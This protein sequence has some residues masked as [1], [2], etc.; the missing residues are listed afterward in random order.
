M[1]LG[2][3]FDRPGLAALLLLAPLLLLAESRLL[4]RRARRLLDR[5]GPRKSSLARD[6]LPSRG[7]TRAVLFAGGLLLACAA[8]MRPVWGEEGG[9]VLRRGVDVVLCLDVSRSMLAQD[10]VPSRLE[11]AKA[12]LAGL[13]RHVDGDRLALVAFAGDARLLV[14][15]TEDG[16]SFAALLDEADPL[17]VGRGGTDLG[18]ALETALDALQSATGDARAIVLLTDGEDLAGHGREVAAACRA[19]GVTVHCVGF[20][21]ERGSK[22]ALDDAG[23]GDAFL[24][25]RAGRDVVSSRD[26]S[27]LRA[28]A[29][30]G[31]GEFVDGDTVSAPLVQLFEARVLP[32]A[33]QAL[34]S[35]GRKQRAQ[36]FQWPLLGALLLWLA[37]LAL[38]E[39]HRVVGAR[40]ATS[41]RARDAHAVGAGSGDRRGTSTAALVALLCA[42]ATTSCGRVTDDGRAAFDDGRFEDARDAFVAAAQG[43]G[44]DAPAVLHYDAALAALRAG[45]PRSA[46]EALERASAA[47]DAGALFASLEFLRGNVAMARAEQAAA[48]AS[49]PEAEPFAWDVAVRRAEAARDAWMSA[50]VTRDDWPEARRNVE[51]AA[52]RLLEFRRAREQAAGNRTLDETKQ[53]R[54]LAVPPEARPTATE[55]REEE[56]DVQ[57]QTDELSAQDVAGLMQTLAEKERQKRAL[58]SERR[59]ALSS[60]VE[61][62]W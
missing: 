7:R 36:R 57:A 39:R 61:R 6:L 16:A 3:L 25:D 62:D 10:S 53:T 59:E 23:P 33:E 31:G 58:R 30:A 29:S 41:A 38:P 51:R 56:G 5:L 50:A 13:A 35:E 32:R 44:A 42:L 34:V 27:G 60:G 55:T 19:H 52:R 45:D 37:E 9:E 28:L 48:Q 24:R 17:A 21:S 26:A 43:D 46:G 22:I 47:S 40:A 8:L 14:P 12:E 54:I 4:A 1:N 15:L 2:E 11:R 18:A 49:G 20:G